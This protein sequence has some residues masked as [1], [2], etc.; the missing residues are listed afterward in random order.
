MNMNYL[1]LKTLIKYYKSKENNDVN[2]LTIKYLE[3]L[4]S[5]YLMFNT[6]D[7][8]ISAKIIEIENN[9]SKLDIKD[10]KSKEII[11]N[12]QAQLSLLLITNIGTE[13]GVE[14]IDN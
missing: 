3:I 13:L 7:V 5:I 6:D 11:K 1:D 2:I 14:D 9:I 10:E 8:S 4:K 12:I